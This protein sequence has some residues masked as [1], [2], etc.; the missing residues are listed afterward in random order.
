M[1]SLCAQP[2]HIRILEPSCGKGVFL[3]A[4]AKAGFRSCVGLEVDGSLLP[5]KHPHIRNKSFVTATF[6]HTFNLVIGNP[7]YIRWKNMAPHQK[8]ELLADPLWSAHCN[9]LSD[10]LYIF[11]LKSVELLAD[12]GEL[13]FITPGYWLSTLHAQPLRNYLADHGYMREIYHFSETSIFNSVSSSFVIFT[14]IKSRQ[15]ADRVAVHRYIPKGRLAASDLQH[16]NTAA[17]HSYTVRQF[18]RDESWTLAPDPVTKRLRA[19]EQRCSPRGKKDVPYAKLGDIATIANGLVSGLDK[20]FCLPEDI[21]LNS[22]EASSSLVVIKAKDIQSYTRATVRRYIFL[23]DTPLSETDLIRKYPTFYTHL[24]P[25]KDALLKRYSY[26]RH[27]NYWDWTFLRSMP[28]F[29]QD[30]Q[31]IFVPSK[32]RIT[33]KTRLRFCLAQ[34]QEYP[35][36]D[37]TA[38]YLQDGVKE[39]IYYVLALLNSAILYDWIQYKGLRKG[40]IAEFSERPLAAIPIPLIDWS[41]RREV[42]YHE[43][44]TRAAKDYM[45]DAGNLTDID[46]L[47]NGLLQR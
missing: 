18:R 1:V 13:V 47:I 23:N 12:E 29:R 37:V 14:Y 43:Q 44:I 41:D 16:I 38:I 17:W 26:N 40:G 19:Y 3:D 24:Q 4:L 15:K 30:R 2:K 27:I 5:D 8:N 22:D 39:S 31:K 42:G 36:Q 9:S 6:D 10:Y 35:T 46:T 28:L 20:A 25:Y 11:I 33:N 21:P 32:E 34:P 7:P 45:S